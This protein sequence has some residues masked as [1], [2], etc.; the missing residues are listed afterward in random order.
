MQ[1]LTL[2]ET[3]LRRLGFVSFLMLMV[4]APSQAQWVIST[5]NSG[6]PP[7]S[8]AA[9]DGAFYVGTDGGDAIYR[10]AETGTTWTA[11]NKGITKSNVNALLVSDSSLFTGNYGAIFRSTDNAANWIKINSGLTDSLVR[12][13]AVSGSSLFAGTDGG[14]IFRSMDNGDTWVLTSAGLLGKRQVYALLATGSVLL[15]GT[16]DFGLFI[17]KDNGDSWTQDTAGLAKDLAIFAFAKSGSKIY[18]GTQSGVYLSTDNGASWVARSNGLGA[19]FRMATRSLIVNG[20]DVYAGTSEGVFLSTDNGDNWAVASTGLP[21]NYVRA[22]GINGSNLF[23]AVNGEGLYE[24]GITNKNTSIGSWRI[25]KSGFGFE[26]NRNIQIRPNSRIGFF[27]NFPSKV[28]L[29][30]FDPA[31]NLV[32][33]LE[34]TDLNSGSHYATFKGTGLRE[35]IYFFQLSAQGFH[36]SL[37]FLLEK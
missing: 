11:S 29:R 12:S 2:L 18:A 4:T 25:Q 37:R 27:L 28:T 9:I 8:F 33:I 1:K 3:V 5:L 21:N 30:V 6:G 22:L 20:T 23:A 7:S 26:A 17:S 24:L 32:E 19:G 13:L 36:Q 16:Q 34:H 10:Y 31:G 15:A 14:K 35:G